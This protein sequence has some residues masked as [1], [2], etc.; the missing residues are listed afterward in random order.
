[1]QEARTESDKKKDDAPDPIG[2][3]SRSAVSN[4]KNPK[5]RLTHSATTELNWASKRQ[6]DEHAFLMV[7]EEA[8]EEVVEAMNLQEC[9]R[10]MH[11]CL[12]VIENMRR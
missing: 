7:L 12:G 10:Q 5:R 11:C 2:A 6:K 8:F 4:R 9:P 1:M 3:G